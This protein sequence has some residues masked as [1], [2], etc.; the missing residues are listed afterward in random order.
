MVTG[1]KI[2]THAGLQAK[3]TEVHAMSCTEA[4]HGNL[5]QRWVIAAA[6][7]CFGT[8]DPPPGEAIHTCFHQDPM[9]IRVGVG[10]HP[11]G[12]R[13]GRAGGRRAVGTQQRPRILPPAFTST[14]GAAEA[15]GPPKTLL[16]CDGGRG[17]HQEDV[18]VARALPPLEVVALAVDSRQQ[19]L[20]GLPRPPSGLAERDGHTTAS[21]GL[22]CGEGHHEAAAV[23]TLVVHGPGRLQEL[24]VARH[25]PHLVLQNPHGTGAC[26]GLRSDDVP[27][28]GRAAGGARGEGR[29]IAGSRDAQ[30]WAGS[31]GLGAALHPGV[32]PSLLPGAGRRSCPCVRHQGGQWKHRGQAGGGGADEDLGWNSLALFVPHVEAQAERVQEAAVVRSQGRHPQDCALRR[33]EQPHQLILCGQQEAPRALEAERTDNVRGTPQCLRQAQHLLH[34][35]LPRLSLLAVVKLLPGVQ[36]LPLLWLL[37]LLRLLLQLMITATVLIPRTSCILWL[38]FLTGILAI[39]CTPAVDS[40]GLILCV[41]RAPALLF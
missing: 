11:K 34:L 9:A 1:S 41:F 38:F 24:P 28:R 2:R 5:A 21:Q 32:A 3:S 29:E 33:P 30:A 35:L 19:L 15:Q 7:L 26:S 18:E 23:P 8:K 22:L 37:R 12:G 14:L 40:T 10:G 36:L 25:Q 13:R 20:Q 16:S 27:I 4:R 17:L 6:I 31:Q 39:L